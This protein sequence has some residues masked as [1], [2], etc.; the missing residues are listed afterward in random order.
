M[1]RALTIVAEPPPD[2]GSYEEGSAIKDALAAID[3]FTS[4]PSY[5]VERAW[6]VETLARV[7]DEDRSTFG[8]PERVQIIG[9]GRVGMLLL[10]SYWNPK[11]TGA[12]GFLDSNPY[13]Y[14][15]L[16]ECVE[17]D[18]WVTLLGC[19]V[20]LISSEG[21]SEVADGPTLLFD[22]SRMWECTVSAPEDLVTPQEDFEGGFYRHAGRLMTASGLTVRQASPDAPP[23]PPSKKLG[24]GAKRW[25]ERS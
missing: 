15:L 21:S 22:L 5:R 11:M 7:L 1:G 6:S 20:G 25:R 16:D 14:G 24:V 3:P 18:T 19:E 12:H 9:H 10:G 4:E 23:T 2:G 8:V 13:V 17:K